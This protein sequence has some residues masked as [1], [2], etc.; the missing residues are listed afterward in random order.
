[1]ALI[2]VGRRIQ[3]RAIIVV[4]AMFLAQA[5]ALAAHSPKT[6]PERG[7]VIDIYSGGPPSKFPSGSR[8]KAPPPG[9]RVETDTIV[10]EFE[11]RKNQTLVI[12]S[13]VE[14]RIN[15]GWAY[16]K[17]GDTEQKFRIVGTEPKPPKVYQ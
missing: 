10:Y 1:M 4:C 9:Y 6:Y 17:Q 12:G 2:P 5:A 15:D 3:L 8:I 7:K 11:G 13:T 16:V 14:F